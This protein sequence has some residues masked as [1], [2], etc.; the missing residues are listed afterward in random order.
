[1]NKFY[2][3]AGAACAVLASVSFLRGHDDRTSFFLIA[4]AIYF[5]SG[6]FGDNE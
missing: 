5:A 4:L 6:W 2:E 1:M 3:I